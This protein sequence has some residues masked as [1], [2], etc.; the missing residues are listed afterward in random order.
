[1]GGYKKR[2]DDLLRVILN[3]PLVLDNLQCP[4]LWELWSVYDQ[5]D[6]E[7]YARAADENDLAFNNNRFDGEVEKFAWLCKRIVKRY[8]GISIENAFDV[9]K[10]LY[11]ED[12]QSIEDSECKRAGFYVAQSCEVVLHLLN[13]DLVEAEQLKESMTTLDTVGE[14]GHL[15]GIRGTIELDANEM[16]DAAPHLDKAIAATDCYYFYVYGKAKTIAL[17]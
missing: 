5:I 13:G 7:E 16:L 2:K 10:I 8:L 15:Y 14:I 9:V 6:Y 1:M 4:F 11:S 17:G 12:F 3:F